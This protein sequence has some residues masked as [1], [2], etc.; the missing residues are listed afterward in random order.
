[1]SP[2]FPSRPPSAHAGRLRR[3]ACFV[4]LVTP[5]FGSCFSEPHRGGDAATPPSSGGD[6]ALGGSAGRAFAAGKSGAR[7]GASA[8]GGEGALAGIGGDY[9]IGGDDAAGGGSTG[10]EETTFQ[11]R[12]ARADPLP[13]RPAIA[14]QSAVG[15]SGS[16][17]SFITVTKESLFKAFEKQTCGNDGCHGYAVDPLVASPD[18]F[19]LTLDSFDQ[20]PT[21]GSD[22]L[23]RVLSSDPDTVMPPG[24]G[25]GSKRGPTNPVRVLAE[26]LLA[27]QKA[28]F[29]ESFEVTASG[30]TVN[31]D[32]PKDPY[33]LSPALAKKLTNLGSCIPNRATTLTSVERE[34]QEKDALF[35]GLE[36]SDDLPDTIF[37]TDLVSLDSSVLA[38]RNVWSYAPTYPLFSDHAGKMR[39]V[40]VPLGKSIHYDAEKRDF[41][42]PDGTRFYKTFLKEVRDKDGNVGYRKMET[43]LIVVRQDER[44]PDGG[45]RTH[46]LRAAYAWDRDERMAHRVKDPFRDGMPAADRMCPYVVDESTP[47]DPAT[48]PISAD[49]SEFCEYMTE[50]ELGDPR[51]G[52]IR[53]Y[54]IPS[55][56]RCDQCHMGSSSHSYILGFTPWQVD[57]RKDGEGGVYEAPRDDELSQLQRLLDYGV[58]TGI[59]PGQ[60]KLEESQGSRK[61]RN[62]YELKAQGYMLGNCAFCHNPHGFPVVQNPALAEFELF[63]NATTGGVFQ[64]PLERYSPRAKGAADQSIRIPYI[65][66]GF[67]DLTFERV[68]ENVNR[69]TFEAYPPPVIDADASPPD[70]DPATYQFTLLGPWRSLIWRNVYTPFTY[71]EDGTIY[72]HM[73]RNAVG[74][75]CRAQ[76]IMAEWMLSVP[77]IPKPI[78]ADRDADQPY[79][80][81]PDDAE[82]AAS[83]DV[84]VQ[85][86]K[87]RVRA[88][89]QGVTGQWC[90][91][92]DDIVDPKV[93]LS[94]IDPEKH[95]PKVTSPP[96]LGV[97][98]P[99]LVEAY[100]YPFTDAVPDHAHWVPTDTTDPADKWVPRRSNWQAILVT[101]ESVPSPAL[102]PIVDHLRTIHVTS[103]L[104]D[105]ALHPLPMG[106][107]DTSCD[108][109]PEL[110]DVPTTSQI[111]AEPTGELGRWLRG[112]VFDDDL[113][114]REGKVH[115][116]TR[117]EAVFRAI[118]Q[119][120]HGKAADSKSP[121]AATI[122]EL[123]GGRTRVANFAAGLLGPPTAPGAFARE[124]FLVDQGGTPDDWQARYVL[125]MGLGGTAADI[126]QSVLNLVAASP[127]YGTAVIAPGA[128][129]PN[130]LGSAQ[131][132]CAAVLTTARGLPA[133]N[134]PAP[135]L[136]QSQFVKGT[137][138]YELWESLCTFENQPVVHVFEPSLDGEIYSSYLD[139]YRAKDE[140]GSWVYPQNAVVGNQLG[141]SEVGIGADN[142]LPWCL[143]A[144]SD[145][146]LELIA[147]WAIKAGVAP[148]TLPMCP[149]TLFAEA[150]GQPLYRL[151]LSYDGPLTD[152]PLGNQEFSQHWLLQGAMNA[153]LSALQY[154]RGLAGGSVTPALPYDFCVH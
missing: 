45:Y 34:M 33:V 3:V 11:C 55:T 58:V 134:P 72:V 6:E 98:G 75:D 18:A 73:P 93:I 46:A 8:E 25:D 91:G 146:E 88:Y 64:F 89:S 78:K 54:A 120:C 116:Q 81:V 109:R 94:P 41:E 4:A 128:D 37:E 111:L 39:H 70:Y 9:G 57:R 110:G 133:K 5:L 19:K 14:S 32:L 92:D 80:E 26:R 121:L 127:F 12:D 138:H 47:R 15:S 86:A 84:A 76:H 51:S 63:P 21:L 95:T 131:K 154:L 106:M 62:D 77:T 69:K 153:G 43:R 36:S 135:W 40:R 152:V 102:I 129:N 29:P 132:L 28:G 149:S 52:K 108:E 24:S 118:C 125:F 13:A 99:R 74:F 97:A 137:A 66:P 87:N 38:K 117:G 23:A 144:K 10:V 107:F 90:P 122:L 150:L 56:Q 1:M 20:R 114:A 60:A 82:H 123:T 96:D 17:D 104:R 7:G 65:T 31:D 27:W 71:Q 142:T 85:L 44:L 147:A 42:I 100:P 30:D 112:G 83:H 139:V 49:S 124:E 2:T 48:N 119:N 59:T 145:D 148:S 103:E 105:F 151:A 53:H 130:M 22:A 115:R 50:Q 79:Q 113:R 140:G 61:P 101:R 126:P 16:A 35:A 67:G 136:L 68:D 143:H 141:A